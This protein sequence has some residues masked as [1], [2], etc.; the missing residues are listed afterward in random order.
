LTCGATRRGRVVRSSRKLSIREIDS[1]KL[2]GRE[3]EPEA[4]LNGTPRRISRFYRVARVTKPVRSRTAAPDKRRHSGTAIHCG[5]FLAPRRVRSDVR[6]TASAMPP[7]SCHTHLDGT[8]AFCFDVSSVNPLLVVRPV[9]RLVRARRTL[10]PPTS[11]VKQGSGERACREAPPR[12]TEP[13]TAD[14][15]CRSGGHSFHFG[16]RHRSEHGRTIRGGGQF[17]RA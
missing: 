4:S 10:M 6:M 3:H 17:R 7:L 1:L 9:D 13:A 15:G 8:T 11:R 14:E 12:F 5:R 16:S 2:A